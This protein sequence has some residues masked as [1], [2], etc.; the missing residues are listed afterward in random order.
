MLRAGIEAGV[1]D[2]DL[3]HALG[4]LLVRRKQLDES[5]PY[6]HRAAEST[7]YRA[8][9]AYVYAL[10]LQKTGKPARRSKYSNRPQAGI[11]LIVTVWLHWPH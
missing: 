9:Y 10:A 1:D 4:L 11:R 3:L 5:L 7:P 8:R 6:L 2:A